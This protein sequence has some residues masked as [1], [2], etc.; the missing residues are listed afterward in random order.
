MIFLKRHYV[1]V[2][3]TNKM[4]LRNMS[5][6]KKQTLYIYIFRVPAFLHAAC[7]ERSS[8]FDWITPK[9]V[10]VKFFVCHGPCSLGKSLGTSHSN[11]PGFQPHYGTIF[12][13]FP[14]EKSSFPW[15]SHHCLKE[16]HTAQRG[17]AQALA[18]IFCWV[19]ERQPG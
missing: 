6:F 7:A 9:Q 18:P 1:M 4:S 11:T 12:F 15:F 14:L 13:P 10:L 5:F 8:S 17:G 16:S 3:F 19:D 2:L